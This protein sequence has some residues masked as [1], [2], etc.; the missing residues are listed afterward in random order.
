MQLLV[1][2]TDSSTKIM[3]DLFE[4]IQKTHGA[5]SAAGAVDT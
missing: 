2:R 4:H 3:L 1:L 5:F